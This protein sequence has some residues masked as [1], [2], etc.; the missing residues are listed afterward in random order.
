V[1]NIVPALILTAYSDIHDAK[2]HFLSPLSVNFEWDLCGKW[3]VGRSSW[4]SDI[5]AAC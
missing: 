4:I 2:H 1:R 3:K 5:F